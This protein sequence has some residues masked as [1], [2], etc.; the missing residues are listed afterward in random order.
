LAAWQAYSSLDDDSIASNPN[1]IDANGT[2]PEDFKRS[3]YAENFTNSPYSTKAGAYITGSEVIGYVAGAGGGG[4]TPPVRSSGIPTGTLPAGQTSA[5]LGLMTDLSSTCKWDISTGITYSSMTYVFASTGGLSHA[6]PISGMHDGSSYNRYVKCVSFSGD[7]NTTDYEIAWSVGVS[8]S[9]TGVYA[10]PEDKKVTWNG[11]VGVSGGIPNLTTVFVTLSPVGG[12]NISG[13]NSAL[14][15]CPDGQVVVLASGV[16][17]INAK[18]NV[19]SGAVLRGQGMS[20]TIIKGSTAVPDNCL[21]RIGNTGFNTGNGVRVSGGFTLSSHVIV[22]ASSIA[23]IGWGVGDI[24]VF[25][26]LNNTSTV[27]TYYVDSVGNNGKCTWC[28][29]DSGDRSLAQVVRIISTSGTYTIGIDPPLYWTF[30]EGFQIE[31][32]VLN[33]LITNAGIESLTLDN[34]SSSVAA[35]NDWGTIIWQGSEG[36]WLKDVEIKGVCDA[37]IY[38]LALHRCTVLR[39]VFHGGAPITPY[40]GDQYGVTRV[41]YGISLY[42]HVGGCLF[43]GTCYYDLRLGFSLG[44][45]IA[46]NVFSYNYINQLHSASSDV[47]FQMA[48]ITTHGA[49]PRF[50]LFEGNY[51][52]GRAR[53]DY[54]WGTASHNVWHR[55]RI[56]TMSGRT[57]AVH[58]IDLH[59]GNRN[60]VYTGNVVGQSGKE[61]VYDIHNATY[62]GSSPRSIHRFGY[63]SDGDTNNTSNDFRVASSLIRHGNWDAATNSVI[64]VAGEY[65]TLAESYYLS[66]QPSWFGTAIPWPPIGPDVTPMY[67][68]ATSFGISPF[69]VNGSS[70]PT[71]NVLGV[72]LGRTVNGN[73]NIVTVV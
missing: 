6:Y 10:L 67:P 5:I 17:N 21:L 55:N 37:G 41:P 14:T 28:G 49:H 11:N 34:T 3:S 66:S 32:A 61:D 4:G 62:T 36:S 12:D 22:M 19:P 45:P 18:I 69:S 16:F 73:M 70:V 40:P 1:F 58:D 38:G 56:T 20:S 35:Q 39:G 9:P 42:K 7:I 2:D 30:N 47:N 15:N 8:S 24:V 60:Q 51:M 25:D 43:E 33:S 50:N 46:G 52:D 64:W 27:A 23:G 13:I 44:G 63:Y 71:S 29:R 26:Q 31:G 72:V 54:V 59:V 68:P 57:T 65:Q 48:A 53:M